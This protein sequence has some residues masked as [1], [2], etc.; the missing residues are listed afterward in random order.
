[1]LPIVAR[2]S[3]FRATRSLPASHCFPVD[4]SAMPPGSGARHL[5]PDLFFRCS[6]QPMIGRFSKARRIWLRDFVT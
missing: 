1:M 4:R 3:F 2:A 6:R 5:A